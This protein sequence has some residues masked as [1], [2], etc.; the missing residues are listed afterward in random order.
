MASRVSDTKH[1]MIFGSIFLLLALNCIAAP[2]QLSGD[3]G[4]AILVTIANN[5]TNQTDLNS[6]NQTDLWSWGKMPVGHALNSSGELVSIPTTT[7][8]SVPVTPM[9]IV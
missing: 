1:L 3:A 9:S 6:Q 5:S 7:D 2:L 4:R 8:G